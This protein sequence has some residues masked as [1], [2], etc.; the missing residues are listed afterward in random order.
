MKGESKVR[1]GTW[2]LRDLRGG[3][4]HL[5]SSP[6]LAMGRRVD[7]VISPVSEERCFTLYQDGSRTWVRLREILIPN[8]SPYETVFSGGTAES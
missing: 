4:L 1:Q 8:R 5:Y 2:T 6:S 7:M 3:W